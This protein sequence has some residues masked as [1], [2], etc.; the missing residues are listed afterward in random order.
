MHTYGLVWTAERLYTYIDVDDLAHRVLDVDMTAQ[1]FYTKGGFTG[2]NPWRGAAKNA[3]FDKDFYLILNVA[4]GG[5]GGYF[6][7]ACPNKP[8]LNNSSQAAYDFWNHQ[9]TWYPTW[10]AATNQ[11]AM[12][13]DWV[14]VW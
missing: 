12:K 14:K 8:W 5:T 13:V 1:D 11:S 4:V 2:F 10:N 3:P 6:P 9:S 7:D